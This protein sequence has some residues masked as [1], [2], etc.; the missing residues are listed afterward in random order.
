[1]T[2]YEVLGLSEDEY[3]K[4][5]TKYLNDFLRIFI[6]KDTKVEVGEELARWLSGSEDISLDMKVKGIAIYHGI[7][8]V[9]SKKRI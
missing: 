8:A 1:M 9:I 5:L 7:S 2:V 6:E 4:K 3:V